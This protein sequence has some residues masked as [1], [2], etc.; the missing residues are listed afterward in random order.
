MSLNVRARAPVDNRS[1]SCSRLLNLLGCT[2]L[3][4]SRFAAIVDDTIDNG[5]LQY[6]NTQIWRQWKGPMFKSTFLTC[7]RHRS[8]CRCAYRTYRCTGVEASGLHQCMAMRIT[9]S[10]SR[11]SPYRRRRDQSGGCRRH[12]A[13]LRGPCGAVVPPEALR[14]L[15]GPH[16]PGGRGL[17]GAGAGAAGGRGRG[18][19]E[20]MWVG[21]VLLGS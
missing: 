13:V 19:G 16:H 17:H 15:H 4:P 12:A 2:L 20:A 3:G 9:G 14:Q 7:K 5:T 1:C 18:A 11:C 6:M 10:C 8:L 21:V